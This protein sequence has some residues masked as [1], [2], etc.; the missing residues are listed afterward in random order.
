[1][2]QRRSDSDLATLRAQLDQLDA[3]ALRDLLVELTPELEQSAFARLVDAAA[4][5]IV[6]TRGR[7][8]LSPGEEP[9]RLAADVSRFA[10]AMKCAARASPSDLDA[11]FARLDAAWVRGQHLA[12]HA[13]VMDIV[14]AL[15]S[16]VDLGHRELYSEVLRTD[17]HEVARRLLVSVYLTTPPNERPVAIEKA[18]AAMDVLMAQ[19][20]E[21]LRAMEET[22]LEPLL[23]L[24][25]FAHAWT[26]HL[27][28]KRAAQRHVRGL[29]ALDGQLREATAR[30]ASMDGL[31]NALDRRLG[32]RSAR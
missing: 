29:W 1:M 31:T 18:G 11:I 20:D 23:E 13:G 6:R 19:Q 5:R 7:S 28:R 26:E 2:W 12:F 27:L 15:E 21:P 16:G 9:Q 8:A 17:V 24:H 3:A 22:A 25:Q 4:R 10:R 30:S 32:P 14:G